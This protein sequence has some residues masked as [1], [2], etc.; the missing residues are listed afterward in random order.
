M[1]PHHQS[2]VDMAK[3]ALT[4][5]LRPELKTFAQGVIDVQTKEITQ[6]KT[7]LKAMK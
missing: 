1:I 3:L 4:K 5:A 2:A 6:Y 7:M